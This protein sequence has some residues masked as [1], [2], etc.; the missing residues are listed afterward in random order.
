MFQPAVY[1]LHHDALIMSINHNNIANAAII[2]EP[3]YYSIINRISKS[4]AIDL[5][6]KMLITVKKVA[7][8]KI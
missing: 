7:Y 2:H 4:V 8:Y 1:T 3:D 5:F 6:K